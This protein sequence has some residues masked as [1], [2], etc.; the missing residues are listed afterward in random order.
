MS[1]SSVRGREE[2][3]IGIGDRGCLGPSIL[4]FIFDEGKGKNKTEKERERETEREKEEEKEGSGN[5]RKNERM[6]TPLMG[7]NKNGNEE[8]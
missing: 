2:T 8:K 6:D 1:F 4:R 3:G 5:G 7:S